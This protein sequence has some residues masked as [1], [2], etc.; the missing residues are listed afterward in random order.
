MRIS[1][2]GRGNS[3]GHRTGTGRA[4]SGTGFAVSAPAPHAAAAV[5]ASS[6]TPIQGIDAILSVQAVDE[7]GHDRKRALRHGEEMLDLLEKVKLGVLSGRIPAASLQAL[8]QTVSRRNASGD[9]RLEGLLDEI[10]LR[11][12]VELAKLEKSGR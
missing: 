12:R 3:V 6:V 9:P 10:E 8:A 1:R 2:T 7:R 5:G 4:A 11:A